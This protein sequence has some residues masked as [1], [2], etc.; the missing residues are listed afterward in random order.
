MFKFVIFLCF[1]CFLSPGNPLKLKSL[2]N[3]RVTKDGNHKVNSYLRLKFQGRLNA[4]S[5]YLPETTPNQQ[6]YVTSFNSQF[7]KLI[8]EIYNEKFMNSSQLS[9]KIREKQNSLVILT[10]KFRSAPSNGLNSDRNRYD[11][12]TGDY[13]PSSTLYYVTRLEN[14]MNHIYKLSNNN[15]TFEFLQYY[16]HN[17]YNN[18]YNYNYLL[19]RALQLNGLDKNQ[20]STFADE[21][22][23]VF[24]EKQVATLDGFKIHR[25]DQSIYLDESSYGVVHFSLYVP[26]F[27]RNKS[28]NIKSNCSCTDY[29]PKFFSVET[30]PVDRNRT[31][32]NESD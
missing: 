2:C 15:L 12:Y 20:T 1:I 28:Q 16:N 27:D 24:Y 11:R 14:L 13:L 6:S 32:S 30:V 3:E 22:I 31:E 26:F 8:K 17:D 23:D 4:I 7:R 5:Y 29:L 10:N 19:E 18:Y 21:L 25:E 9:D